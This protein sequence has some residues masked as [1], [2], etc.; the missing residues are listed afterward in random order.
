[1]DPSTFQPLGIAGIVCSVLVWV[2]ID[3]RAQ[4]RDLRQELRESN[5]QMITEVVPLATRMLD[6]LKEAG[7]IVRAV[8]LKGPAE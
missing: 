1:V 6:A 5:R 8:V 4:I 2:I 7:E 3:Q